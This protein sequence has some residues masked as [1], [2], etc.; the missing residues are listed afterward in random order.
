MLP[1]N[2]V[3]VFSDFNDQ[4]KFRNGR[5]SLWCWVWDEPSPKRKNST[6]FSPNL[7]QADWMTAVSTSELGWQ[8]VETSLSK[9]YQ[10]AKSMGLISELDGGHIYWSRNPLDSVQLRLTDVKGSTTAVWAEGPSCVKINLLSKVS[11][12]Q[13][14]TFSATCLNK[15]GCWLSCPHQRTSHEIWSLLMQQQ[16]KP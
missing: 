3:E 11:V 1:Q 6:S 15:L 13:G 9:I 10:R 7:V 4:T 14:R 8:R 2:F 16:P 5:F 12:S